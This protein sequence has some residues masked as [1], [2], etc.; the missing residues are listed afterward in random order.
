MNPNEK[1]MKKRKKKKILTVDDYYEILGLGHLRWHATPKDIKDAYRKMCLQYHPDKNEGIDDTI[2]KKIQQAHDT[3]SNEQKRKAYDSREEEDF[4]EKFPTEIPFDSDFYSTFG[5]IFERFAKFSVNPKVPSLGDEDTS[6]E[7]VQEFYKFWDAFKSWRDYSYLDEYDVAEAESR[8]ER[9]WMEKQNKKDREKKKKEEKARINRLVET[10]YNLD[11]RIAYQKEQEK[12]RRMAQ[13]KA[14]S[15]A[16]QRK[17][18]EQ[19][20]QLSLEREKKAQEEQ[21]KAEEALRQK[22]EREHQTKELQR[23]RTKLQKLCKSFKVNEVDAE[24]LSM[25]LHG[26]RL[27]AL[28]SNLEAS[29]ND[30]AAGK[31]F[32]H[33]ELNALKKEQEDQKRMRQ[34][35]KEKKNVVSTPWKED[36]LSKLAKAL[37]KIPGGTVNRWNLIADLI[38]TRSAN[39]IIAKAQ[40]V[41]QSRPSE[42]HKTA[43]KAAADAFQ[44]SM[45]GKENI[46]IES[47]LTQRE[48]EISPQQLQPK[49]V[50]QKQTQKQPPNSKSQSTIPKPTPK[51]KPN[52]EPEQP[53][54]TKT[55][56]TQN[57]AV[58]EW[59]AEQQKALE[60]A[61]TK[62]P[63]T[64]TDRWDRIASNVP[65]KTKKECIQRFKYLAELIKSKSSK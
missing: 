35:E 16:F 41:K 38:P 18:E 55:N 14:K 57:P 42:L 37:A 13:Q 20:R 32:F 61:L 56:A 21:A 52:L 36:E 49:Q 24:K 48:D 2:F 25:E 23:N 5:I 63:T 29:T 47:P 4:P 22:K 43:N 65:D 12:A 17:R 26:P 46:V 54:P 58:L 31:N 53:V 6:F 15:E 11:P 19:E 59:S 34:I 64:L 7:R 33:Q 1:S 10:A 40:E 8:E 44:R 27:L 3:L 45:K 30:S 62:Y 39:E 50:P 28:L 60:I 9:R 51:T